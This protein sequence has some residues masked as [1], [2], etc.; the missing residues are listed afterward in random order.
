MNLHILSLVWC[1]LLITFGHAQDDECKNAPKKFTR[2]LLEAINERR[3]EVPGL[4]DLVKRDTVV[5][6]ENMIASLEKKFFSGEFEGTS[7]QKFEGESKY[8][9]KWE[10]TIRAAVDKAQPSGLMLLPYA[11]V[12][13]CH[14][15]LE[16]S[17]ETGAHTLSFECAVAKQAIR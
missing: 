4:E 6:L 16:T 10:V 5:C 11:K 1:A 13:G 3:R 12:V 15:K 9:S 17:T 8:E 2:L 7:L 14:V